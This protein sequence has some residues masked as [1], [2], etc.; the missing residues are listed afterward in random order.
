[1]MDKEPC[2]LSVAKRDFETWQEFKDRFARAILVLIEND[3]IPV[4]YKEVDSVYVIKYAPFDESFGC[5][6]PRWLSPDEYDD[7]LSMQYPKEGDE[8]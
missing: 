8:D 6:Y 1:M 4:V 5:V 3:Y 2:V 7:F